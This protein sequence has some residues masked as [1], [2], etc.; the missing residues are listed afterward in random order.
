MV[1]SESTMIETIMIEAIVTDTDQGTGDQ[2]PKEMI[3]APQEGMTEIE[4]A[5]Q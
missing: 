3:V 2:G 1:N 4:V 5:H